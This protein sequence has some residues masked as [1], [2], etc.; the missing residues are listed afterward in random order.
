MLKHD[1]INI[2]SFVVNFKIIKTSKKTTMKKTAIFIFIIAFAQATM[3]QQN[4]CDFEG[5]KVVRFGPHTGI[6]DTAF[7]NPVH[8]SID[9]SMHCAKYVRDTT[10]YDNFKL[11][12]NAKLMDVSPYATNA[13]SPPKI[14]MKLYSSA[15]TGTTV[16]LQL[17]SKNMDN[18][19]TG[20]HSEYTAKTTAQNAWQN[21]TFNYLLSPIGSLVMPT[22]IDKI[23]ILFHPGS[24]SRDTIYFDDLTGPSLIGV[25][26]QTFNEPTFKLYQN[27]PNPA[28]ENTFINFNLNS[29]GSVSL[30]LYDLLGNSI[31]TLV[32]QT[33]RAGTYAIPLETERIPNGI[34]F[35]TLTKEGV[36]Q[37]VKMI[38]SK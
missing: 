15:P 28:R 37:T 21:I 2:F 36:S 10:T 26:I 27:S 18:Y 24:S 5:T 22:D 12:P 3:G 4:Y 19:P 6:L 29:S 30:K 34:Y 33:M 25:G 1:A 20:I 17:G 35:Y 16:Q 13:G 7:I 31:V 9:S 11:Y 38:V 8:N 14:T 32:D 23:V